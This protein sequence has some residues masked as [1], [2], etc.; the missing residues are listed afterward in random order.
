MRFRQQELGKVKGYHSFLFQGSSGHVM[1]TVVCDLG[2]VPPLPEDHP[3]SPKGS[4][5]FLFK[6]SFVTSYLNSDAF[7]K[8]TP[9]VCFYLPKLKKK[10]PGAW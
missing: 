10:A 8:H 3:L 6:S 9:V 7:L 4:A 5:A 2:E 1:Q